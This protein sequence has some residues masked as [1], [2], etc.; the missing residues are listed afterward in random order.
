MT[1]SLTEA[2]RIAAAIDE[3]MNGAGDRALPLAALHAVDV[4]LPGSVD[5]DQRSAE[6]R[7][8]GA[9]KAWLM[10]RMADDGPQ[11]QP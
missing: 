3:A 11:G 5:A 4:P 6:L 8:R 2:R 10:Q 7:R 1:V 9:D